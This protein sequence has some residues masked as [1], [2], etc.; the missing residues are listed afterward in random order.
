MNRRLV[1]T[2]IAFM[3]LLVVGC[4][5]VETHEKDVIS[6]VRMAEIERL[7]DEEI[8]RWRKMG[9][10]IAAILADLKKE[11]VHKLDAIRLAREEERRRVTD[12]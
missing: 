7:H 3:T 10:E 2:F 5:A 11:H 8:G 12:Q 4:G 9:A 6:K 1:I